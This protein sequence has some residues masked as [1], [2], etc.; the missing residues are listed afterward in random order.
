MP[1]NPKGNDPVFPKLPDGTRDIDYSWSIAETWKQMEAVVK[2]GKVK[3]I[4]VSNF[5][6]KKLEEILPTAE[7][8]PAVDQVCCYSFRTVYTRRRCM[9]LAIKM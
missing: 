6:Q 9:R 7:I 3:A 2:K 1:L 4:G 5:S 8:V